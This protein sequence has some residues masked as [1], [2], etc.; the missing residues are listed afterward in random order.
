[1]TLLGYLEAMTDLEPMLSPAER[2][3]LRQYQQSRAFRGDSRWPG[4]VRYLGP[5][6]E[7]RAKL[8]MIDRAR[9]SA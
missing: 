7:A 6:P 5:R 2:E 3:S 4:W 8:H 1:M 9:R